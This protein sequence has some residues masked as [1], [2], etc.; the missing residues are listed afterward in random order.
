MV[1]HTLWF[2]LV[3]YLLYL[4]RYLK[5][6]KERSS[7]KGSSIYCRLLRPSI[8]IP[9]SYRYYKRLFALS[10]FKGRSAV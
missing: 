6:C 5:N 2:D 4:P 7:S 1:L 9:D 10:S 3:E 8:S